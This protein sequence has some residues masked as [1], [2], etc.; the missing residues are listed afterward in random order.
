MY[1]ERVRHTCMPHTH[2]VEADILSVA[3][4]QKPP[5]S[6]TQKGS[7]DDDVKELQVRVKV[8]HPVLEHEHWNRLI[9][10]M[11]QAQNGIM[12]SYDNEFLVDIGLDQRRMLV[13]Q[14][15]VLCTAF[16]LHWSEIDG[17]KGLPSS[18]LTMWRHEC[19]KD[20]SV[21]IRNL[22]QS[23]TAILAKL[24]SGVENRE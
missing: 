15:A 21:D 8:D 7:Q 1:T 5:R 14:A 19:E 13:I 22:I 4:Y 16:M 24:D 2:V 23:V 12:A 10:D 18:M 9:K 6:K 3:E 11:S 17:G 20:I